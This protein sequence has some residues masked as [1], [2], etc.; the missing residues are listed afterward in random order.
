ML[1]KA[2]HKEPEVSQA[3]SNYHTIPKETLMI[4]TQEIIEDGLW[5]LAAAA[6]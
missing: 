4:Q 3:A 2:A 5:S 1:L 6:N